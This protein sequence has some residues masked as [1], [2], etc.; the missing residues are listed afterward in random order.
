[1]SRGVRTYRNRSWTA[2]PRGDGPFPSD[3]QMFWDSCSPHA[4]GWSR[5]RR[6]AT[7]RGSLLPARGGW[8]SAAG[9][10]GLE[11][12]LIPARG[13]GPHG[14]RCGVRARTAPRTR[15]LVFLTLGCSPYAREQAGAPGACRS[16][17]RSPSGSPSQVSGAAVEGFGRCVRR[18]RWAG[19]V[20][21]PTVVRSI[22]V[23]TL[24]HLVPVGVVSCR[25]LVLARRRAFP[26]RCGVARVSVAWV[27]VR[28]GG[29]GWVACLFR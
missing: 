2:P 5:R 19:S 14:R 7:S 9:G 15:C 13:E 16:P 8:S 26:C 4:R 6:L 25:P 17:F 29:G 27:A 1:M 10:H 12:L 24:A 18:R 11:L 3:V 23:S 28:G 22:P 21:V 20:P